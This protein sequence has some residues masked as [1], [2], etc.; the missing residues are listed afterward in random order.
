MSTAWRWSSPAGGTSD[1]ESFESF[2]FAGS[3][4]GGGGA[5]ALLE[6]HVSR[7]ISH[8]PSVRFITV[9]YLPSS[10]AVPLLSEA[11]KVP[12]SHAR[13]PDMPESRSGLRV[14]VIDSTP[15]EEI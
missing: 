6:F 14:I 9:M 10:T 11:V 3:A 5:G 4:G 1:I 2:Y 8:F 13:S 7:T 15:A 12:D